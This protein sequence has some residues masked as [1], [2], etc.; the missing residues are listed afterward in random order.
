MRW[1][2]LLLI[3]K[4]N[5]L[6]K[7]NLSLLSCVNALTKRLHFASARLKMVILYAFKSG[8]P[9]KLR[10]TLDIQMSLLFWN[11][12]KIARLYIFALWKDPRRMIFV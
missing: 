5:F 7:L 12:L 9:V 4:L 2:D 6:R 3:K 10:S 11:M 8:L 1:L